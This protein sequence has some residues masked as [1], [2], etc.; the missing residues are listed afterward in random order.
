MRTLRRSLIHAAATVAVLTLLC[1]CMP[2]AVGP[3]EQTPAA[4]GMG[5]TTAPATPD[6]APR[7]TPKAV[8][9]L[10]ADGLQSLD[11]LRIFFAH[12]S[13]GGD[14][15]EKGIPAVYREFDL[16]PPPVREGLPAPDGSFGDHW[17]E[18]TE[19]PMTKLQDFDRWV[20]ME[21]VGAGSDIAFM[22]LGFVD[23]VADTDVQQVFDS[24]RSMM[25]RL[26]SDYPDVVFLHVTVS[27][28]GWQP[29]NNEAIERYN[30][31][32]RET[33]ATTGRLFDLATVVA[34]C[35]DG[36]DR[37]HHLDDG[38][39][40]HD[41]CNDYSRDGGHLNDLGAEVAATALL[42]LL[43]GVASTIDGAAS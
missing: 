26:E 17:L 5:P 2:G 42:R 28:T 20:R 15:V 11:G 40:Y 9:E 8:P 36:A 38:R 32:L 39:P 43:V 22:K 37:V 23:I 14:I 35:E 24:Y 13:V 31:L 29:E 41:I 21:G 16:D 33:Y 4:T 27:V 12:R 30:T 34:T 3:A 18:Q 6:P 1:G 25:A 7:P 19:D 10:S